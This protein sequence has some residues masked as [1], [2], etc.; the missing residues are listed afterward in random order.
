[1]KTRL[2]RDL[3]DSTVRRNVG[4]AF[5]HSFLACKRLKMALNE[6]SVIGEDVDRYG[7][8]IS[9][10]FQIALKLQGDL[11]GYERVFNNMYRLNELAG[12]LN[13]EL[14]EKLSKIKPSDYIGLSEELAIR[15]SEQAELLARRVMEELGKR[16]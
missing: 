7:E 2:Q 5:A 3:S 6:M 9:E 4:V 15:G 14:K 1:M 10:A 16:F 12:E 11:E 13:G 8:T